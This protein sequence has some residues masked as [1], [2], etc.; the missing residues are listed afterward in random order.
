MPIRLIFFISLAD[1]LNHLSGIF[2]FDLMKYPNH[3]MTIAV[4]QQFSKHLYMFTNISVCYLLQ[5]V[6]LFSRRANFYHEIVLISGSLILS[7]VSVLILYFMNMIGQVHNN[8]YYIIAPTKNDT[9]LA[10]WII[11]GTI[12]AFC[13]SLCL[14]TV[15][16]IHLKLYIKMNG[17]FNYFNQ[18]TEHDAQLNQR[19][20]NI[21]RTT[22]LF[23]VAPI[24][25]LPMGFAQLIM[26]NYLNLTVDRYYDMTRSGVQGFCG[27]F[28]LMALVFDFN[29]RKGLK[30]L[31][32]SIFKKNE[33]LDIGDSSSLSIDPNW[34]FNY[35]FGDPCINKSEDLE[36]N[37]N[38]VQS[39]ETYSSRMPM[40]QLEL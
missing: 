11:E 33:G 9:Q 36:N 24:I 10:L 15:I 27:V 19:I 40:N 17:V 34:N 16:L 35:H 21:V 13:I 6:I 18:E 39:S 14:I 20:K 22:I 4:I 32:Y 23:P 26:T 12:Q 37:Q 8:L 1:S 25:I 3:A 30:L 28:T 2:Y 5:S 38:T 31:F 29:F 7:I